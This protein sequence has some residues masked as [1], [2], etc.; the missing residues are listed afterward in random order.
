MAQARWTRPVVALTAVAACVLVVPGVAEAA[1]F[2]YAANRGTNTISQ[3]S[4]RPG[5]YLAVVVATDPGGLSSRPRRLKFR[6]AR[7]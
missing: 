3:Y 1:W 5:R 6:V 7:R 4:I 2:A